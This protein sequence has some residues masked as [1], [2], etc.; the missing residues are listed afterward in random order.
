MGYL[1]IQFTLSVS[2]PLW[3]LQW[4]KSFQCQCGLAT[5]I[6]IYSTKTRKKTRVSDRTDFWLG[7]EVKSQLV[8]DSVYT[9][10]GEHTWNT[11]WHRHICMYWSLYLH[12][13]IYTHIMNVSGS[14][15][16]PVSGSFAR[17]PD[18]DA[19]SGAGLFSAEDEDD[20]GAAGVL[21][22]SLFLSSVTLSLCCFPSTCVCQSSA[23]FTGALHSAQLS[24]PTLLYLAYGDSTRFCRSVDCFFSFISR[25]KSSWFTTFFPF[26]NEA[27]FTGSSRVNDVIIWARLVLSCRR[28]SFTIVY[29]V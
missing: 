12:I 17:F 15:A 13:C 9:G 25:R 2:E 29:C 4:F 18:A 3:C 24:W 20:E 6:K 7:S 23:L 19:G 16:P 28:R 14:P 22:L 27:I 8:L 21:V 11:C 1:L 26:C 10:A 5:S